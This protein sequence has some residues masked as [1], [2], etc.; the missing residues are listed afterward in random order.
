MT[1]KSAI[2]PRTILGRGGTTAA[3]V[4]CIFL[5][6][7]SYSPAQAQPLDDKTLWEFAESLLKQGEYYRA[8]SEYQRMR[9]YFPKSPLAQ[10]ATLRIGEA[11]L[12]GGESMEAIRHLDRLLAS[13]GEG[14]HGEVRDAGLFLRGVAW[15]EVEP[16]APYPLRQGYIGNALRDLQ[17]VSSDW[18]VKD[19]LHQFVTAIE[20]PPELPSKSPWLAGGLST[21]IPGA[22][23]FYVGRYAEGALALFVN[24]VLFYATAGAIERDRDGAALVMG[25]LALAFY[26]GSIYAAANGAHKYNDRHQAAY[27]ER[28]RQQFGI[29]L[30]KGGLAG[31]FRKN[32]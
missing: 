21:L 3:V 26:G 9:H 2:F 17:A 10:R 12:L 32:F 19:N 6:T 30:D 8:V 23:S 7:M 28:Q 13:D 14:A 11:M 16:H 31:V 20:Q 25:S 5:Y 29:M 4:L 1:M 18:P 15:L 22:G 27:L 24:G